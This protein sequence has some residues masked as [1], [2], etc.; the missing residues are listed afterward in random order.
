MEARD[1]QQL[2][3]RLWWKSQWKQW[4]KM[5]KSLHCMFK[6][7]S[8]FQIK[9]WN[10]NFKIACLFSH[11]VW[12]GISQ[13]TVNKLGFLPYDSGATLQWLLQGQAVEVFIQIFPY[14]SHQM[15]KGNN[16]ERTIVI[17]NAIKYKSLWKGNFAL[18]KEIAVNLL[19]CSEKMCFKK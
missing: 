8:S 11:G 2:S 15:W 10:F 3:Q 17:F 16:P 1:N 13:Q 14:W 19:P 7:K 6:L 4:R 5:L 18:Q 9:I 12:V